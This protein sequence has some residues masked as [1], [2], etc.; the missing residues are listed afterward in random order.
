MIEENAKISCSKHTMHQLELKVHKYSNARRSCRYWVLLFHVHVLRCGELVCKTFF[1]TLWQLHNGIKYN[2]ASSHNRAAIHS[3]LFHYCQTEHVTIYVVTKQA[4]RS[5][6]ERLKVWWMMEG[7][8]VFRRLSLLFS[9]A[10]HI[11]WSKLC[12]VLFLIFSKD[13]G[14]VKAGRASELKVFYWI[15]KALRCQSPSVS[16]VNLIL[17]LLSSPTRPIRL[18][19]SESIKV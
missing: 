14:K 19:G 9:K 2:E 17:L 11:K 15:T 16:K 8:T 12:F 18:S 4:R 7:L 3:F 1:S 6:S 10:G 13:V 5:N